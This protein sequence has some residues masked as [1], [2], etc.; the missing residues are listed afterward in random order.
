MYLRVSG[1]SVRP[2][3]GLAVFFSA[4]PFHRDD[5]LLL[6]HPPPPCADGRTIFVDIFKAK[7][8]SMPDELLAAGMLPS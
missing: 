1:E 6:F 7:A 2:P 5:R 4:I 3:F 8:V